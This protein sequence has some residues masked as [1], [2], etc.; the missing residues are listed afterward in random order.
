MGQMNVVTGNGLTGWSDNTAWIYTG[1]FFDADGVFTFMENID[2]SVLISIDGVDR[3]LNNSGTNP[4]QTVT[5]TATTKGQRGNV[6]DTAT[7]NT[8]AGVL[9]LT[10]IAANPNLPAGWHSIE[11]RFDNGG[12]GGGSVTGNGFTN[13]YGFG[14]NPNGTMALDGTQAFRP[15][16]AGDGTLFRTAASGRGNIEIGA[17]GNAAAVALNATGLTRAG[18]ITL[19][20]GATDITAAKLTL[21]GA[22]NHDATGLTVAGGPTSFGAVELV[23][24][25]TLTVG[26][27]TVPDGGQLTV[28]AAGGTG[29]LNITTTHTLAATSKVILEAG[30]LRFN[31]TGGSVGAEVQVFADAT[32][33]VG[34]TLTGTLT[35]NGGTLTGS[36]TVVGPVSLTGGGTIAPGNSPGILTVQSLV[37]DATSTFNFEIGAPSAGFGYDQLK[38][39]GDTINLDGATLS[40]SV[41]SALVPDSILN[42]IWNQGADADPGS[43][44]NYLQGSQFTLPGGNELKISYFDDP[45]TPSIL[46][47]S[48]GSSVSLL[49]VVPEPGS[50]ALLLGGL[51]S[52]LAMRRRRKA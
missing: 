21:T 20:G 5:S 13:N 47:M 2:D 38:V 8:A 11:I 22:S 33:N 31:G 9:G 18:V 24:N 10:P 39:T 45:A 12:G 49:V 28:N 46:E 17:T 23:A 26:T 36:G 6:L 7:T 19:N 35:V 34:G 14:L 37:S 1:Y 15:I 32:V 29:V 44:G 4:W 25:S 40:L 48:G 51:G 42:I 16:D 27:L 50:A 30:T 41:T 43:F 3:L 52:L